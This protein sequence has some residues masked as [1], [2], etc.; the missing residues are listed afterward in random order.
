MT[1]SNK[2][3]F[4]SA[5]SLRRKVGTKK[6]QEY[7]LIVCEGT[8]TE[9]YYFKS[10]IKRL[11]PHAA[12]VEIIGKGASNQKLVKMAMDMQYHRATSGHPPFDQV[13]V[14][15]DKDDFDAH[16]FDN[17]IHM[18]KANKLECAWSNEAFELWYILHFEY[19]T[20]GMCRTEYKKRLSTLLGETYKK[21]DPSMYEKLNKK[22]NQ[23][24][25]IK[26]SKKLHD[27]I[28][29]KQI[30]PSKSN[31]CT[32]VYKLVETLNSFM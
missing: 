4:P 28:H 25:A 8:K 16:L 27:I 13:W 14:V 20:T 9:P 2:Y 24:E 32:T 5:S 19:R 22:G 31:P 21:N 29:S 7:I 18:G 17:A 1:K 26:R 15:F 12:E 10:M 30:T 3:K 11:P 23:P 6:L